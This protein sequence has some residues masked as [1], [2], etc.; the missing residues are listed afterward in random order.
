[1]E[2]VVLNGKQVSFMDSH[3]CEVLRSTAPEL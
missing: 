1:M 3:S 2:A